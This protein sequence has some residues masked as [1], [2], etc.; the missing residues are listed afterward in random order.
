[1][2]VVFKMHCLLS[3]S[4]GSSAGTSEMDIDISEQLFQGV[5]QKASLAGKRQSAPLHPVLPEFHSALVL[6]CMHA[7]VVPCM[8]CILMFSD[9]VCI[10]A[11]RRG[12]VP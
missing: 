11:P 6:T 9:I 8:A 1:M 10:R 3:E 7:G 4:T 5:A 12:T 2:H